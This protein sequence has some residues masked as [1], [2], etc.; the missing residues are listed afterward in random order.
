MI[1]AQRRIF[2][3]KDVY[4]YFSKLY[5]LL[6]LSHMLF[7]LNRPFHGTWLTVPSVLAG[8][9]QASESTLVRSISILLFTLFAWLAT[10]VGNFIN[11][12]YDVEIDRICRPKAPLATETI[13]RERA[14]KMLMGEYIIS[15]FILLAVS[16]IAQS[17]IALALGTISLICTYIYSAPP[18]RMKKR[19][20][21][22][23]ITISI[24]YVAVVL[25]GWAIVS[26]LYIEAIK[27]AGFFGLLMLGIGFSKDFMHFEADKRFCNTPPVAYGVRATAVIASLSLIFPIMF[28][29]YFVKLSGIVLL[30][31][32][33]PLIF[34]LV[35]TFFMFT[36][37]EAENRNIV[38]SAFLA[39]INSAFIIIFSKFFDYN[40]IFV[41][42]AIF[43]SLFIIK[44]II[45]YYTSQF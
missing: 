37:P 18:I 38:M 35:S 32:K 16:I 39:Y 8:A 29:S 23:P 27:F 3:E 15:I 14:W 4:F 10:C 33:I 2:N 21:L 22:G 20:I 7:K 6:C 43:N 26:R 12:Y 28:V 17:A 31:F 45:D 1:D 13:S 34:A 11:D 42:L 19:G 5:T 24:A 40:K 36:N 44:A 25:G 9:L 41:L 30:L